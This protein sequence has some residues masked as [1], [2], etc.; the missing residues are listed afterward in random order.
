MTAL[1]LR[2]ALPN[3]MMALF[4]WR[5]DAVTRQMSIDTAAVELSTHESWYAA[6][7]SSSSCLIYIAELVATKSKIAMLRFEG[8]TDNQS[9][10]ISINL[11]PDYR[12]QGLA[13]KCLVEGIRLFKATKPT[14]SRIL[15]QIKTNNVGSQKS[16]ERAGFVK[17]TALLEATQSAQPISDLLEYEYRL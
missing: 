16:F 13:V 12:G 15:A 5:N 7:L 14:C 3:D 8:N 17:C 11:N 10:T 6:A 2:P 1:T 9:F 4:R